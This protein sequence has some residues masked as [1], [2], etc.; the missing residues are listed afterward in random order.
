MLLFPD[1]R[2]DNEF[3]NN[4]DHSCNKHDQGNT[5]HPMH[6]FHPLSG[7]SIG[8]FFLQVQI[9][10]D[11]I[12]Y[13]HTNRLFVFKLPF[14]KPNQMNCGNYSISNNYGIGFV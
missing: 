1:Q 3:K 7:F 12:E 4:D 10:G 13:A 8:V 5:V 14:V 2:K 11:L 9:F 6:V